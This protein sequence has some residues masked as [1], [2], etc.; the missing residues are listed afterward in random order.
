MLLIGCFQNEPE[1]LSF[2]SSIEYIY[3]L[4][5]I[6]K[7]AGKA[8][9]VFHL[10]KKE[11]SQRQWI[12]LDRYHSHSKPITDLLFGL[13][14]DSTYPRLLS[15][16]MDRQLVSLLWWF[17]LFSTMVFDFIFANLLH[18]VTCAIGGVWPGKEHCGPARHQEFW[19]H[20]T[21][22]CPIVYGV[23]SSPD[24]RAV[25]SYCLRPIQDETP[26]QHDQDVQVLGSCDFL[27]LMSVAENPN[28]T[29]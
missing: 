15:L 21:K 7:D 25:S 23:V 8:V 6:I 20:W 4:L 11:G 17:L 3:F 27:S 2:N 14:L 12:C 24:N 10:Q 26:Q 1:E 13:H 16:G 22:C 5:Y 18:S 28:W 29:A 19:S 9:T